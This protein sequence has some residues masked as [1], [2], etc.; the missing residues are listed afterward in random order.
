MGFLPI[1][2]NHLLIS[3]FVCIYIYIYMG[4]ND[5]TLKVIIQRMVEDN[6]NFIFRFMS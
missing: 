3:G 6:Y 5:I 1:K 2:R 4:V